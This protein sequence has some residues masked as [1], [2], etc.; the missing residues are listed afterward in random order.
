MARGFGATL[1]SGITDNVDLAFATTASQRSWGIW[2]NR[3]EN[4]TMRIWAKENSAGT[5]FQEV[6]YYYADTTRISLYR[7]WSTSAGIWGFA[8]PAVDGWHH[9]LVT[10][11]SGATTN[12]AV[13][14]LDG[15]SQSVTELS[16]PAGSL[17]N[18][19][20]GFML[21]NYRANTSD[22]IQWRGLLAEFAVWDALLTQADATAL[23]MGVSPLL[24]RRGSLVHYTPLW[25]RHAAEVNL[26]GA[27]GTV[28]GTAVATH[29]RIFQPHQGKAG[30]TPLARSLSLDSS[31]YSVSGQAVDLNHTGGGWLRYTRPAS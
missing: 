15:A 18:T 23:G 19:T 13:I 5:V 22:G 31:S 10:Y 30:S 3:N 27:A 28:T 2:L 21:G 7:H 16:T 17:T 6:L 11:D 20:D 9:V 26:L 4:V 25:G 14:Y 29:P 8:A 12:D 24:V 1:G